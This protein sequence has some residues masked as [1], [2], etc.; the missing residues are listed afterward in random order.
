MTKH[1]SKKEIPLSAENLAHMRRLRKE[2]AERLEEMQLIVERT[3][4][5]K[6]EGPLSVSFK[7]ARGGTPEGGATPLEQPDMAGGFM[8]FGEAGNEGCYQDPPG[9]CFSCPED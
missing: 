2:V 1:E 4:G 9:I 7:P 5:R 3:L 8:R 6:I